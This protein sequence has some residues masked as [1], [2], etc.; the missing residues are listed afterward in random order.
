MYHKAQD[1]LGF[2]DTMQIYLPIK[3]SRKCKS[4]I[5]AKMVGVFCLGLVLIQ[6]LF[7]EFLEGVPFRVVF[8]LPFKFQ[9][10]C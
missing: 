5:L 9:Q 10:F 8:S 1:V 3:F 6:G 4:T 2:L 7:E